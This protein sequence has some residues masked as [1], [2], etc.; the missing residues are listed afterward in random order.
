MSNKKSFSIHEAFSFGWSTFFSN[1][2]FWTIVFFLTITT[3]GSMGIKPPLFNGVNKSKTPTYQVQYQNQ[4]Q[5]K[6]KGLQDNTLKDAELNR[7]VKKEYQV[8][9]DTNTNSNTIKKPVNRINPSY[10]IIIGIVITGWI[11]PLIVV[12][13]VMSV[14]TSIIIGMGHTKLLINTARKKPLDY[15]TILSEVSVKKAFRVLIASIYY[16]FM[17]GIGLMLFV[18]PGIYFMTKYIWYYAL[19]V[20]KDLGIREAFS[21]SSNL[22]KGIKIKTIVLLF[23]AF[24][25]SIMSFLAF[26]VGIIAGITIV[27]LAI[28]HVYNQLYTQ[29]ESE[30]KK[31]ATANSK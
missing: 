9:R 1:W 5:N 12:A 19:I 22:S 11:L 17:I 31:I 3:Y 13:I 10:L 23:V 30:K 15:K 21:V 26:G 27:E 14:A 24:F 2:K 20:D 6:V 8:K 18:I 7:F 4:I 28:A 29:Y 25:M 16:G